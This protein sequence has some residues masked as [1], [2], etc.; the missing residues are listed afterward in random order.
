[1]IE[2]D[3]NDQ[4]YSAD[5][6]FP[7]PSLQAF[8]VQPIDQKV[9]NSSILPSQIRRTNDIDSA[10]TPEPGLRSPQRSDQADQ[11]PLS[12]N[13]L[14]NFIKTPPQSNGLSV[15]GLDYFGIKS[16]KMK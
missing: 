12:P 14:V 10:H 8:S 16:E 9:A 2:E 5:V 7:S 6:S 1:M 11:I 4:I 15:N 3:T 13:I